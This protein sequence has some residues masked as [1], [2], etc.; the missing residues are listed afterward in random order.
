MVLLHF[1]IQ[2]LE[3]TALIVVYT[4]ASQ[5]DQPAADKFCRDK[6]FAGASTWKW[7]YV[8]PTL[9]QG[10]GQVLRRRLLWWIFPD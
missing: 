9:V 1:P 7:E 5:C 4:G 3:D 6:G 10:S 2:L 8:K